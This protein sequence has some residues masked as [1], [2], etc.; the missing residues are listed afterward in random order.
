MNLGEQ[1]QKQ[2]QSKKNMIETVL[3]ANKENYVGV[4]D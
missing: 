2:K 3:C 1:K 4:Y